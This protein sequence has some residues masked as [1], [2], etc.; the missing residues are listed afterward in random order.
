MI[1]FFKLLSLVSVAALSSSLVSTVAVAAELGEGGNAPLESGRTVN[2]PTQSSSRLNVKSATSDQLWVELQ[3]YLVDDGDSKYFDENAAKM[4]GASADVIAA[5]QAFNKIM[6]AENNGLRKFSFPI[7]GN[8]CGPGHGGESGGPVDE[9]DTAC[10]HHDLCYEQQGYFSCDCDQALIDEIDLRW[11]RMKQK[12]R[13]TAVATK[14]YFTL[15]KMWCKKV[16]K[17]QKGAFRLEMKQNAWV[18]ARYDI[19]WDEA[20]TTSD[21]KT[22][23][24]HKT[25]KSNNLDRTLGVVDQIDFPENT[26]NLKVKIS[27]HTGLAWRPW[28]TVMESTNLELVKQRMIELKGTA[29]RIWVL[30]NKLS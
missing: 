10:M 20:V 7:W 17:V 13:I 2:S 8:W 1:R 24:V 29:F 5:G 19:S 15:Q 4:A 9:L 18:V 22:K 23:L 25:W 30:N 28:R 21:G 6:D 12:E 16:T 26:Q 27:T 3:K 14:G 11:P